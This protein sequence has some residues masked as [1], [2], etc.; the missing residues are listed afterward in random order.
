MSLER[1]KTRP[2]HRGR[3]CILYP[4]EMGVGYQVPAAS[5]FLIFPSQRSWV[6]R[7]VREK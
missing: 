1:Q 4:G 7:G 3:G 6:L 2:L 5:V